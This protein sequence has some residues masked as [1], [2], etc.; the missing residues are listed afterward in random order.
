MPQVH[1][2]NWVYHICPIYSLSPDHKPYLHCIPLFSWLLGSSA[3]PPSLF[4][5]HGIWKHVYCIDYFSSASR[6]VQGCP[7]Q[8]SLNPS[9]DSTTVSGLPFSSSDC[10]IFPSFP[11]PCQPGL[12]HARMHAHTHLPNRSFPLVPGLS[13]PW[14]GALLLWCAIASTSHHIHPP[15]SLTQ[16]FDPARPIFSPSLLEF[17]ITH[18]LYA[19]YLEA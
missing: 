17:K 16:F 1:R 10:H 2:G 13:A 11:R 18:L 5:S 19:E 15:P 8:S 12:A 4:L 7:D 6:H 9:L 3:F 14:H